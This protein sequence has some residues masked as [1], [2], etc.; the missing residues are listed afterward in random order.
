M[1]KPLLVFLFLLLAGAAAFCLTR[2]VRS[3]SHKGALLDKMPELAWVRTELG[4]SDEQLAKVSELHAAYR[5]K[6]E[7]MCQ[8]ILEAHQKLDHLAAKDQG[9]T[10]ELKAAIREHADIHA[11]CQEAMLKHL[12]ETAGQMDSRQAAKYLKAMLPYALD[13]SHSEPSSVHRH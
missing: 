4:L 10:D 13:F 5:P 1:K 7:A 8:R 12:Y 2:S 3:T 9:I 11:E 6:C